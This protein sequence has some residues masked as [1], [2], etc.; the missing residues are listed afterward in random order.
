MGE[1]YG[2]IDVDIA[3]ELVC[4]QYTQSKIQDVTE[5]K[6]NKLKQMTGKTNTIN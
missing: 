1:A 5:N 6:Y 2:S 4:P 3:S